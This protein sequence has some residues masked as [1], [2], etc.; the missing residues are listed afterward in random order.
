MTDPEIQE[1]VRKYILDG[2]ESDNADCLHEMDAW[3]TGEESEQDD[4]N[5]GYEFYRS[6]KVTVTWGDERK[7]S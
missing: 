6:A 4:L 5:K 1:I 2:Y 7:T 3:Q